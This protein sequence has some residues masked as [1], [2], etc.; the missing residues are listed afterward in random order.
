M[1]LRFLV[2][3]IAHRI[4]QKHRGAFVCVA[5]LLASVLVSGCETSSEVSE[6]PNPVK[7]RVTLATPPAL[8]AVGGAGSLAVTTQPECV[9]D[10]AATT[11]WISALSPASGKDRQPCRSALPPTTALQRATAPFS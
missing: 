5:V 11:D 3:R 2:T 1:Q 8:D 7:C 4:S 10:A 9:W 6:G